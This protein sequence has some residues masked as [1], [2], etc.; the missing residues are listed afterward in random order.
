MKLQYLG[1]AAAEGIPGLFCSCETCRIARKNGGRDVRTRSQAIINDFLLIDFPCDTLAHSIKY[2]IDCSKI[3]HCIITHI[4]GD[5]LYPTE[6]NNLRSGFCRL[7]ENYDG[8]HM[9]G[10][11]DAEQKLALQLEYTKGKLKYHSVAPF[12]PFYIG[13]LKIT[14][15]K[16]THGTSNPYIYMIEENDTALMYAHDTGIF[17]EETWE[18]LKN[19]GIVFNAVSL[20]CTAGAEHEL[21]YNGHM[22][23]GRNVKC[24]QR[25][26]DCGIA[27]AETSFILNHFSHNGLSVNYTEFKDIVKSL[28]F[29]VSYDGMILG[30]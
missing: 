9:Y 21:A 7:P 22:C 18:Y 16:A 3:N 2:N 17:P 25:M 1:T 4:H 15:L 6:L 24:R 5:H 23:L 8:F 13:D 29:E 30:I 26:I 11:V 20:D 10:S 28:H 14:A 12:E 27:N 19:V